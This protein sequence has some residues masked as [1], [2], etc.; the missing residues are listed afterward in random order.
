MTTWVITETTLKSGPE[1]RLAAIDAYTKSTAAAPV[2]EVAPVQADNSNLEGMVGANTSEVGNEYDFE[3]IT[4]GVPMTAPDVARGVIASNPDLQGPFSSLDK[5]LQDF[6]TN[7]KGKVN[8]QITNKGITGGINLSSMS[9]VLGVSAMIGVIGGQKGSFNV[10]DVHGQISLFSNLLRVSAR[11]GIPGAF[12]TIMLA[13]NERSIARSI[14]KGILGDIVSNSAINMLAELAISPHAST[15]RA[16]SPQFLSHFATNFKIPLGTNVT[17]YVSIGALLSSSF[18]RIDP[19][20][21]KSRTSAGRTYYNANI[22]QSGS[23]DFKRVMAASAANTKQPFFSVNVDV[24][25]G[26]TLPSGPTIPSAYRQ[27]YSSDPSIVAMDFYPNGKTVTYSKDSSGVLS[28][29]AVSPVIPSV[30]PLDWHTFDNSHLYN[31]LTI[32]YLIFDAHIKST[33]LNADPAPMFCDAAVSAKAYFPL[34]P[35]HGLQTLNDK[36]FT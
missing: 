5:P 25:I 28:S 26:N 9:N 1:D 16:L 22:M 3:A 6:L 31:P 14:I 15:V 17:A 21:N 13:V 24:S 18:A 34:T 36:S 23:A 27:D 29:H 12:S 19:N 20:W 2:D 35:L 32:G 11:F 7:V 8:L 10:T 33:K 4:P 30:I